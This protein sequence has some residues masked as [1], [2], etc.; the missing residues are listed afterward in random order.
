LNQGG[1]IRYQ[2]SLGRIREQKNN[3]RLRFISADTQHN[4]TSLRTYRIARTKVQCLST[5]SSQI[6]HCPYFLIGKSVRCCHILNQLA[7]TC[8]KFSQPGNFVNQITLDFA[9]WAIV[10]V[11]SD[12]QF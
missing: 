11:T 8:W 10:L 2:Q 7:K 12:G 6:L 1:G 5:V 9:I 4:I 3:L